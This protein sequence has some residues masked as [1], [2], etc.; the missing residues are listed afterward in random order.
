MGKVKYP[1]KKITPH[2]SLTPLTLIF[3]EDRSVADIQIIKR[4][5]F[6]LYQ[7]KINI[8]KD[9][10][11][12]IYILKKKSVVVEDNRKVDEIINLF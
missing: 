3:Q 8:I 10:E 11:A 12:D 7:E 9:Q 5:K 6:Q 4:N 2:I 1:P